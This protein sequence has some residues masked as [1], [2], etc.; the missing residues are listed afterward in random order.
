MSMKSEFAKWRGLPLTTL[1]SIR[2]PIA[3]V[4]LGERGRPYVLLHCMSLE[5]APDSDKQLFVRVARI[6]MHTGLRGAIDVHLRRKGPSLSLRAPFLLSSVLKDPPTL[7][8][9]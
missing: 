6:R 8:L 4:V 2:Q 3:K 7:P 9:A 1:N 5:V